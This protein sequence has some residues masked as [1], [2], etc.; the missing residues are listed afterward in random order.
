MHHH[1]SSQRPLR[2][3]L[4]KLIH[5]QPQIGQNEATDVESEELRR[6][7]DAQLE[8]DMRL[9]RVL[10]ARIFDLASDLV[11]KQEKYG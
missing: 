5:Q 2:S 6:V 1:Q 11:C 3:P 10:E 9:R 7:A 4:D 8:T